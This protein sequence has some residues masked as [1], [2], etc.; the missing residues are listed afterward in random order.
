MVKI[1][2]E[3]PRC[4]LQYSQKYN[5]YD[6]CLPHL[7][8]QDE[9]YKN[10]FIEAKKQGRYIIMDNSLHELGEAYSN[11]RLFYWLRELEPNEF[12]VPD[13][14]EDSIQTRKNAK[15]WTQYNYPN[16]TT[17]VAVV[18]AISLGEALLCYQTLK[19]LGYQKIAFSYGASYYQELGEGESDSIKKANGRFQVIKT[20]FERGIIKKTDRVHLLG[21]AVP[22]E[23]RLYKNMS[24]IES[25]DT[26]NPVMA[27]LDEMK[28]SEQGLLH[29]PKAN[30]N[31]HYDMEINKIDLELLNHN[32]KMFKSFC[33]W[34]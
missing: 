6:F 33:K 25:I 30:I 9:E 23:F 1:N 27:A 26:S 21:C 5:S 29:K 7:L 31:N 15:H 22:Q 2:H 16:N 17:P 10:Y 3:G 11:D 24:F 13:V 4:L 8:D 18:Q 20:L 12:I 34:N 14:W 19:D 28:Y 32:V